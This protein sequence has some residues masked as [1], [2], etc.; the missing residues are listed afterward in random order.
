M[1]NSFYLLA[2][3]LCLLLASP[4]QA[5]FAMSEMIIDFASD[6]ARQKDVEIISQSK[7]TQYISTD[8]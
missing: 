8:T 1:R 4:A 7:E 2:G 3:V 5:Q 6:A